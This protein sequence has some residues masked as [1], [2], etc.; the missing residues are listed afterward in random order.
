MKNAL[1]KRSSLM[2]SIALVMLAGC[3]TQKTI[4]H[5]GDYQQQVYQHFKTEGNSSE[6]QIAALEQG[7]VKARAN[8]GAMPPGYHAHLGMLYARIGKHDQVVQSFETE[9]TL[10]PESSGYIDFLL[11]KY[12]K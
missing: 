6:E 8:G 3:A 7:I 10:F 12:R 5:W 11:N 4:Y 2:L 1:T 9:K